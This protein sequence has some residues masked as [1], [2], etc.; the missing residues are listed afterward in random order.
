VR[1]PAANQLRAV[2]RTANECSVATWSDVERWVARHEVLRRDERSIV[3]A[4]GGGRAAM[5]M[6]AERLRASDEDWLLL[7]VPIMAET[8]TQ[9]R[10][11]LA[12][13]NQLAI[14]SLAI[15]QGWLMLKATLPIVGVDQP[16]LARYIDFMTR[17]ANRLRAARGHDA[18]R[19]N[20]APLRD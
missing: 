8:R 13:D 19:G 1:V 9:L 17:E 16:M 12:F 15:E 3:F 20:T 11:A 6:R 2:T 5:R 4:T 18:Q 7:L 10:D 14:G